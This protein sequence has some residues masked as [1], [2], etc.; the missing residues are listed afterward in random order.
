MTTPWSYNRLHRRTP[1]RTWGRPFATR[2]ASRS[3]GSRSKRSSRGG[4]VR[5][6]SSSRRTYR[7]RARSAAR[8]RL[9]SPQPSRAAGAYSLLETSASQGWRLG[10]ELERA[11][12]RRVP[13]IGASLVLNHARFGGTLGGYPYE[14][15]ALERVVRSP[16]RHIF[17]ALPEVLRAYV[18]RSVPLERTVAA[19]FAGPP[20]VA[21]S[22]ALL[23]GVELRGLTLDRQ[24][25]A[26]CIGVPRTTPYLP[27]ERPNPL[28]GA[29]LGLGLALRLWRDSFPLAEGGTAILMHRFQRHFSH[30]T[31]QPYRA[32]F[33]AT[34]SSGRPD[35]SML[36]E[37]ERRAA[38]DSRA[39]QQYRSGR[40]CHPLLPFYDWD[41]CR[42]ALGRVGNVLIAGCRD[43]AAARQLG[44]V[45]THGLGAALTM[46]RGWSERPPRVAFLLSPPYFPLRVKSGT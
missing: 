32:F 12:A 30:P 35:A 36:V 31:Q 40:T 25:D 7:G 46:V 17:R 39:L 15:Q 8:A 43:H 38:S 4:R 18:L 29:Y 19:A 14:E 21:H 33:A 34:R 24:L 5:R 16:F 13:V 9:R 45:P 20:S 10:L 23:R 26:I 42:P 1:S 41:G 27:R 11:L 6:S 2:C 3:P 44:F 37:A 28:L 22:E